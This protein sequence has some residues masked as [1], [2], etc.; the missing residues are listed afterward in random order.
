MSGLGHAIGKITIDTSDITRALNEV[1]R[2]SQLMNAALGA[3]GIGTGLAGI[4]QL[5]EMAFELAENAANANRTRASFDA[6]AKSVGQDAESML[7]D[8]RKASHGMVA[9][10]ELVLHANQAMLLNVAK[11]GEELA[12]LLDAA[13]VLGQAMGKDTASSFNDLVIGLGRLSPRILD[14]LG[15]ANEGEKTFDNYAKSIGKTAKALTDA[16][17]K[18]AL[19][20]QVMKAAQPLLDAEAKAGDNAANKMERFGAELENSKKALGD[21]LLEAGATDTLDIFSD[22]IADSIDQLERLDTWLKTLKQDFQGFGDLGALG[23]FFEEF[24]RQV[25]DTQ[26]AIARFGVRIGTRA[27]FGQEETR[28]RDIA[29]H[30]NGPIRR[31]SVRAPTGPPVFDEEQ[32]ELIRDRW[33]DIQEIEADAMEARLDTTRQ[34]EEQR[35]STLRDFGKMMV[36]DAEDFARERARAEEDHLEQIADIHRDAGR[37]EARQ[38][39]DL[40][41]TL[42]RARADSAE[43]IGE[44][45]EDTEKRLAKLDKDF[46]REQERR[47]ADFKDDMLSAAGRLDAIKL[48]ELRKDRA[49]ELRDRK[50]ANKEQRDDLQEQLN[51]RIEDENESLEKSIR[52]AREAH[53]RQ[54]EDAREADA[55]RI[56]DMRADFEERK[57]R[58]DEDHAIRLA[59][60]AED[61]Q[62]RLD[63]MARQHALDLAQ[64]D[65]Q[66]QEKRAKV[67]TE[68]EAALAELGIMTAAWI[69]EN[70]RVTDVAI[71]DYM[72]VTNAIALAAAGLNSVGAGVGGSHPS[73]ADPYV[74]RPMVPGSSVSLPVPAGSV[75]SRNSSSSRTLNIHS[76]AIVIQGDGL[77]EREVVEILVNKLEEWAP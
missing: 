11:T 46:Q 62:D 15:I 69:K 16:E 60:M 12:Q 72:R 14:N 13:R 6:L 25:E 70:K 19:I 28:L 76:G 59:R 4:R 67:Q 31:P 10:T 27:P 54:L 55:Q 66:E 35:N 5:G 45:R 47:E 40:E 33:L 30:G 7:N 49:R 65:E 9:D 74:D 56:E 24:G 23:D 34:Y 64:I 36:R 39:E 42:S 37:R 1:R 63:E 48:L 21:L 17:K 22:S 57:A 26:D 61:H 75:S 18:Q 52:Q 8:M 77:N 53:E 50:E 71:A 68:F 29:R 73:L 44:A 58:E 43:R 38:V 51:E 41:R 3:I 20:N 32:T 2:G